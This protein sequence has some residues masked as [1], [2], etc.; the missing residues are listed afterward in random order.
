[1]A[2]RWVTVDELIY[3][4]EQ[5]PTI[6]A[7][8]RILKG[9]QR[10]RD[11]ALLEAAAGRPMLSA[12]GQDAYPTLEEKAAALLHGIARNHPFVDGNKRTGTVA[13]M[14]MLAINGRRVNW[15]ADEALT[16][17]VQVAEGKLTPAEFARWLPSQAGEASPAAD[18]AQ[19]AACIQHILADQ[20]WLLD[21]LARR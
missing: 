7:I 13:A 16:A 6:G 10:V 3:I 19:D 5:I 15:N 18:A 4:N 12:F 14:Y 9:K 2:V 11:M 8:H 1:V 21:Q 17:I 20:A